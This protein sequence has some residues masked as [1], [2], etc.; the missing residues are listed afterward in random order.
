MKIGRHWITNDKID[1]K[2]YELH[3]NR[4]RQESQS[5]WPNLIMYKTTL[6]LSG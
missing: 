5:I 4:Q 3:T 1:L 6:H 2:Y